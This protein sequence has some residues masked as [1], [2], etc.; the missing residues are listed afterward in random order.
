LENGIVDMAVDEKD[1]YIEAKKM[2]KI[3]LI[4]KEILK[5]YFKKIEYK[6]KN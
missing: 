6:L 4:I 3:F 5:K 1:M 2:G